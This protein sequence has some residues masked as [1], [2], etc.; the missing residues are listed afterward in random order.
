MGMWD[1]F[2][3]VGS[4]ATDVDVPDVQ[5][6][7]SRDGRQYF[8]LPADWS[9][10]PSEAVQRAIR[11]GHGPAIGAFVLDSDCAAIWFDDADGRAG[12][13]AINPGYDESMEEHTNR[14]ADDGALRDAAEELARWAAANAPKQPPSDA[15]LTTLAK[16]EDKRLSAQI[17]V[18]AMVFAEDGLRRF[19]RT[20]SASRLAKK[21]SFPSGA[22]TS[23]ADAL[24]NPRGKRR[25]SVSMGP[26]LWRRSPSPKAAAE[27]RVFDDERG[28]ENGQPHRNE[29]G[30]VVVVQRR[31]DEEDRREDQQESSKAEVSEVRLFSFSRERLLRPRRRLSSTLARLSLARLLQCPS[32]RFRRATASSRPTS[33]C[34]TRPD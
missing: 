23:D 31:D 25:F 6:L 34:T 18:P 26:R 17:G 14:W 22:R 19:S 5:P 2:L 7:G 24:K 16:L 30:E 15:I 11:A 8:R 12:W 32:T 21:R 9:F 27:T 29:V 1:Q 13:I 20:C 3:V 33:S 10:A 4:E 28:S